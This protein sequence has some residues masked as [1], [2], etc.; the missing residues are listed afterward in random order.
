[1]DPCQ[2]APLCLPWL[3]WAPAT[4]GCHALHAARRSKQGVSTLGFLAC[5]HTRRRKAWR[6]WVQ[7]SEASTGFLDVCPGSHF[8]RRC[9]PADQACLP[10]QPPWWVILAQACSW[11]RWPETL[12]HCAPPRED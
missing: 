3:A 12:L 2:M 7:V 9:T 10:E 1:M 4:A 8:K 6:I 5:P 11:L